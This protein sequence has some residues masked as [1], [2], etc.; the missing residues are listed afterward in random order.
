MLLSQYVLKRI[1]SQFAWPVEGP[2][3]SPYGKRNS[4]KA[5]ASTDHKGI[6]I[7]VPSGTKVKAPGPGT[8]TSVFYNESGGNQLLIKHKNGYQT[9]Y[10]HLS[11]S[12]VKKGDTVRTGELIAYSGNTGNSTGA[13]LHFSMRDPKGN[14]VDPQKHLV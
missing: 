10:A 2:I 4:P 6:D 8:V 9:G 14:Y 12:V 5:G 1:I 11:K 3:T 7:G 13:H